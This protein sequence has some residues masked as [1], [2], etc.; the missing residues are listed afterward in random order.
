MNPT[1]VE[2]VRN[3]AALRSRG[4]EL[5]LFGLVVLLCLRDRAHRVRITR[6]GS[7]CAMWSE[8]PAERIELVPPPDH[9]VD[10]L[11]R[12]LAEGDPPRARWWNPLSWRTPPRTAMRPCWVG[13]I[14][15]R[16]GETRV[17][18]GCDLIAHPE[19]VSMVLEFGSY[20]DQRDEYARAAEEALRAWRERRQEA[21][22]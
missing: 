17:A 22:T 9:V 2:F 21:K 10:E 12:V 19:G 8:S 15:A 18:I 1:G 20:D 3:G 5:Y 11:Y 6:D 7:E 13:E 4:A 16:L 14:E